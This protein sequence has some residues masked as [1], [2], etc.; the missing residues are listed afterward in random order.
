MEVT[1]SYYT[2]IGTEKEINQ[3]ALLIKVAD[4]SRG[5]IVFAVVCDG[6]GGLDQGE[7]ASKEAIMGMNHWFCKVI[8]EI[9]KLSTISER[10]IYQEWKNQVGLINRNLRSYAAEQGIQTGTTLS[11]LLIYQKRYYI[12]HIGDSR[13][14]RFAHDMQKMTEDHTLVAWE[15]KTGKITKEQAKT[16]SRRNVLLQ[17]VGFFPEVE[18]QFITGEFNEDTTFVLCSD[19]FSNH[20]TEE[21]LWQRMKPEKL[22]VKRDVWKACRELSHQAMNRG[23]KDNITVVGVV[24]RT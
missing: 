13:I 2:D 4:S 14:Y 22:L 1:V 23:E 21:E 12:G 8:P 7:I 16:D 24:I 10:W 15:V 11:A 6:M 5:R 17:C 18:L 9:I 20:I 3:D 19:G